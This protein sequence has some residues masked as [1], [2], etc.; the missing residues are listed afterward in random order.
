MSIR[1]DLAPVSPVVWYE[2]VVALSPQ[3]PVVQFAGETP[4]ELA[5][6][7]D[8]LATRLADVSVELTS[9]IASLELSGG[10]PTHA[11]IATVKAGP[12]NFVILIAVS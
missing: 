1:T 3:L 12:S 8:G 2:N 10:A 5:T 6:S 7:N 11:Q 4:E 9:P